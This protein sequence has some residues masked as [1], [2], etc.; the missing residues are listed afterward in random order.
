MKQQIKKSWLGVVF[1]S[2]FVIAGL[3]AGYGI[4]VNMLIGYVQSGQWVE[5]SATLHEVN[6]ITKSG[7]STTYTV[8]GSYSYDYEGVTYQ[9]DRISLSSGS[10]NFGTYWKDLART[11]QAGKNSNEASVFVNPS[12]PSE[13]VLDRTLRWQSIVIGAIFLFS[14]SSA[15]VCFIWFSLRQNNKTKDRATYD[16]GVGM[17]SSEKYEHWITLFIGV[18]TTAICVTLSVSV[19]PDA[20]RDGEYGAAFLL[21]FVVVGLGLIFYAFKRHQAFRRVGP[22]PLFLDPFAP[23]VGGELGGHFSITVANITELANTKAPLHA[24]LQCTRITRSKSRNNRSSNRTVQWQKVAPVYVKQTADGLN[25]QFL[26]EIPSDCAPTEDLSDRE[27][28]EWAVVVEGEFTSASLGQFERSWVVNVGDIGARAGGR[29]NIPA[30]FL[31]KERQA[32]EERVLAAAIEQVPVTEDSQNLYIY[33]RASQSPKS[34]LAAAFVG[35]LFAG[36]GLFTAVQGWGAGYIFICI[37]GAVTML[38]LFWV[39]KS[40]DVKID[41]KSLVLFTQHKWFGYVY[42][43]HQGVVA[44]DDQFIIRHTMTKSTKTKSFEYYA[45]N[46]KADKKTIRIVDGIEGKHH[47]LALIQTVRDRC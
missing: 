23:G 29:V 47:A 38:L 1:G 11:L 14:F 7:D 3:V 20:L 42:A 27:S 19:L 2:L 30:G 18:V 10:D 15:G 25:G 24:T 12:N 16:P 17:D 36:Y 34:T 26:F 44:D 6:L 39:G 35:I 46:F 5:V 43:K 21:L 8:K 31:E 45:I 32:S 41:K 4:A 13:S 40:V 33:S 37:G 9:G 28:I 22:T